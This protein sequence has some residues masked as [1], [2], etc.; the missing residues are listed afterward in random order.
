MCSPTRKNTASLHLQRYQPTMQYRSSGS[1]TSQTTSNYKSSNSSN[2]N[3]P[4]S[5]N[6]IMLEACFGCHQLEHR[7]TQCPY[8]ATNSA[9]AQSVAS[10]KTA[11]SGIG[12][13]APSNF[14]P[15]RRNA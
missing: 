14:G 4:K 3:Q 2:N 9:P 8:K 7:V 11:A 15:P 6:N 13:T 12:R 5:N 10:N 1:N